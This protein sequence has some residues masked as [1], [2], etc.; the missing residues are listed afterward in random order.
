MPSAT[1]QVDAGHHVYQTTASDLVARSRKA[2][3]EGIWAATMR[4]FSGPSVLIV[5]ELAFLPVP[6]EEAAARSESLHAT[7]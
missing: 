1:P 5:D 7:T 3:H 2:A 6:A 4:S